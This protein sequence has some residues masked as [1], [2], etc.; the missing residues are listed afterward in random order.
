MIDILIL[1][2]LKMHIMFAFT[3]YNKNKIEAY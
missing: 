3:I 1:Y 2:K